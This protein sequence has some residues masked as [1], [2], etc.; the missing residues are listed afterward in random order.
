MCVSVKDTSDQMVFGVGVIPPTIFEEF[1][2]AP[3]IK[4]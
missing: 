3:A 4:R 2:S 1:H